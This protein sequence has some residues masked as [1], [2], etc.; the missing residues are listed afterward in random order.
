MTFSN[1]PTQFFV[2]IT[3]I[4]GGRR[5]PVRAILAVLLAMILVGCSR[6]KIELADYSV[7]K[8]GMTYDEVE[9]VLSS[10]P[11]EIRKG[12]SEVVYTENSPEYSTLSAMGDA[13][14]WDACLAFLRQANQETL[15]IRIPSVRSIG[16]LIYTTWVMPESPVRLDTVSIAIPLTREDS[17]LAAP[18]YYISYDG[19]DYWM[20]ESEQEYLSHKQRQAQGE[21]SNQVKLKVV[22]SKKNSVNATVGFAKYIIRSQYCI[23]FD[24]S[25]GRVTEHT[26]LPIAVGRI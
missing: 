4:P 14:H 15:T 26:Y 18:R 13:P 10:K 7:V 20:A 2:V 22:R 16:Q 12:G 9:K 5:Y 8:V 19:G 24:S 23:I 3:L 11:A 17:T 21:F 25:S 6:G 1:C